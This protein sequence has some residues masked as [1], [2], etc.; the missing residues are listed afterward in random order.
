[1]TTTAT[2][3]AA[4]VENPAYEG[5]VEPRVASAYR[6]PPLV[7]SSPYSATQMQQAALLTS[8]VEEKMVRVGQEAGRQVASPAQSV[9]SPPCFLGCGS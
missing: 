5:G 3:A 6:H 7:E 9:R 4:V 1:M 2:P 8:G